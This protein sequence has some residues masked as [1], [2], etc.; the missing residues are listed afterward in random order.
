MSMD[1][2]NIRFKP[3]R[4]NHVMTVLDPSG[5][6]TSNKGPG[7]G[8]V[9]QGRTTQSVTRRESILSSLKLSSRSGCLSSLSLL[10]FT[11]SESMGG[12]GRSVKLILTS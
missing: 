7:P 1:V 12:K 10:C 6:G 2:P 8:E 11:H 3:G 9:T 4:G 5:R